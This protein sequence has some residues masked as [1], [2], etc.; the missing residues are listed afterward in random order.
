MAG[1]FVSSVPDQ[2]GVRWIKGYL[3]IY[4]L[5]ERHLTLLQCDSASVGLS[6]VHP[7]CSLQITCYRG[8]ALCLS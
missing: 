8:P 3:L 6:K 1:D 2:W 5:F 7:V 4:D